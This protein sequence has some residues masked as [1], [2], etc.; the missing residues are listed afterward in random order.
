MIEQQLLG[1]QCG[2]HPAV[3]PLLHTDQAGQLLLDDICDLLGDGAVERELCD[4]EMSTDT[5]S[6]YI[7]RILP[8]RC[9][10]FICRFHK[11]GSDHDWLSWE[12]LPVDQKEIPID[13]P[14]ICMR[15]GHSELPEVF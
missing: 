4:P 8:A 3:R 10:G 11:F 6:N 12:L 14:S 15:L 7:F 1:D 2:C 5:F 9:S 13:A